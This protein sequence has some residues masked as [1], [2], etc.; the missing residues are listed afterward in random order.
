M[1]T[2]VLPA[3]RWS[4]ICSLDSKLTPAARQQTDL[5]LR[6]RVVKPRAQVRGRRRA[7]VR[8]GHEFIFRR[9]HELVQRAEVH[10]QHL[11]RLL[12]HLPDAE[13]AQQARHAGVLALFNGGHEVLSRL[14]PMCPVLRPTAARAHTAPLGSARVPPRSATGTARCRAR[15][16]PSPRARQSAQCCAAAAPGTPRPCSAG[17]PPSG[18]RTTG[19]PHSGQVS[20]I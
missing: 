16:Y 17:R 4:T 9:G 11:R 18:S 1:S 5:V 14:F 3:K 6:L 7:D 20:G 8:Y 15:R 12:P 13:R 2:N 10:G 19:A